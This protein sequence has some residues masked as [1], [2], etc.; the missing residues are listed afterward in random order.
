MDDAGQGLRVHSVQRAERDHAGKR[1]QAAGRNTFSTG[2]TEGF[3]AP[4]LVV[5][6]TMYIVAPWPNTVYALDLTKPGRPREVDESSRTLRRRRRAWPAAGPSIAARLIINGRMFLNLLDGNTVAVDAESGKEVW[7]T[8]LADIQNGE[9][10]TMA[11]L[12]AEGKVL[13]GNSG[14]EM[15]VRG[16]LTALDAGSGKIVWRAYQHRARQGCAD[17]AANYQPPY[18]AEQGKDLGVSSWPPGLLEDWR[19][20]RLGLDQLRSASQ[21]IYYGTVKPGPVEPG[22]ATRRQQVHRRRIRARHRHGPGALVLPEHAAR[23]LRPRRRS[24]RSCWSII[25]LATAA[26]PR[27]SSGRAATVFSG[28][29]PRDRQDIGR[30]TVRLHQV[31][32]GRRHADRAA[33]AGARR[34]S[35][36]TAGPFATFAPPRPAPRTGIRRRSAPSRASSISRTSTFA[37]TWAFTTQTISRGRRS[38]A[39]T[40]RCIRV[41]AA[42][43]ACS[44]PGIRSRGARC[45]RSRKICRYGA[46]RSRRPAA[47]FSTE[48]WTDG[49]RRSTPGPGKLLWQFKTASGIIGQP[50]SYRGPDGHQYIAV[51]SG[52]GGWAGAIV[53]ADL[54][55]KDP[56]AASGFVNA[57]RTSRAA[58]LPVE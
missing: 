22:A 28:P 36:S 2:T 41:P 55:P 43:A 42:T 49:S 33:H 12:V 13:V 5:N 6:N 53:S 37:W 4:P 48:P 3:E 51:P 9:T 8:K 54:D 21:A 1:R 20:H 11:P 19:R 35:P 39:P 31:V 34:R 58:R 14:G 32:Q 10:I 16:W 50:I 45:S 23:S 30:R 57:R 17:R 27:R 25:P 15:G 40:S 46:R 18:A 47:S 7:R 56:T 26:H 52:I 29:G 38:S 24:T 44:P